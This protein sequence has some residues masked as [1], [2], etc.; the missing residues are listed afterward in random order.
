MKRLNR[1]LVT[2]ETIKAMEDMS[3]F[4]HAM[5]FDDL[6]IIAQRETSCF[7]LWTTDGLIIIDAIW[8]ARPA[9]DAIVNAISDAGWGGCPVKKL[10][11][12]RTY[13]GMPELSVSC[14]GKRTVPHGGFKG[15]RHPAPDK[16][17]GSTVSGIP[18]L[19][20]G[21]S[22]GKECGRGIK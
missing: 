1:P 16:G 21:G 8:P 13:P 4:T 22:K 6:L 20:Y 12:T 19:F 14:Y 11:H 5:I 9:F 18:G 15:R 10:L 2:Q 7:V 17:G 3:F